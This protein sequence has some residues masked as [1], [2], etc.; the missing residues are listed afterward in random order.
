MG[1][2]DISVCTVCG[3]P[4]KTCL[5]CKGLNITKPWRSIT[6]TV[7]CYKIFLVLNQYNNHHITKEA[8]K[9]QLEEIP[10]IKKDLKQSIQNEID[11]IMAKFCFSKA[12]HDKYKMI[13]NN[14]EE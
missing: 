13:W 1:K 14:H 7:N 8:A 11:A 6:D 4:Y 9:R 2:S 12:D 3:K 5:S 10:F